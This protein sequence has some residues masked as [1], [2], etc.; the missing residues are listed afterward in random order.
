MTFGG[1]FMNL[2][3]SVFLVAV[4][5]AVSVVGQAAEKP[6]HVF[7]LSGQSNMAG[8]N[9]KLGLEPEA[10]K[11][12]PDAEV[13]YFK[14]A[15]GG[16]PIRYWVAEW[17]DI[18]AKHGID[19]KA[20]R[21]KDK[22]TGTLYYQPI[23][24]QYRKLTANRPRPTSVTFCWMQGERDAREGLERGLRRGVEATDREP[25]AGLEAAGDEFRDWPSERFWQ[26]HGRRVAE[27]A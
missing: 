19:V 2:P 12:F 25:A 17:D 16:Q 21:A 10:A 7:I 6:I 11:L 9:P 1:A 8:M 26:E 3:R 18:A 20:K 15:Q 5:W 27:G 22:S 13:V 24:D 23:L 4:V 14:V